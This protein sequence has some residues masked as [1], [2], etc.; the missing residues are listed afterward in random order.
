VEAEPEDAEDMEQAVVP[1]FAG[2]ADLGAGAAAM[3]LAPGAMDP[4]RG[5]FPLRMALK[6]NGLFSRLRRLI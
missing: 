3:D 5:L 6:R 4:L 2:E 1:A